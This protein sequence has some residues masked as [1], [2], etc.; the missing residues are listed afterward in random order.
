MWVNEGS[1]RVGVV[2][3]KRSFRRAVERSRAKR[4]L[5]EA[6]RLNR[7]RLRGDRDVILVAR[8]GILEVSR[9]DVEK[10][11]L[12]LAA[13]AGILEKRDDS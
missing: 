10:E 4:L 11:L 2:A 6:F 8:R 12:K 3:A 5:R 13:G 7:S 9:Q 1:G